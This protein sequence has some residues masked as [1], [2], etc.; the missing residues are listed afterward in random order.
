MAPSCYE[1]IL[2]GFI[3]LL[4][5]LYETSRTFRYYFKFLVYYGI[6]IVNAVLLMPLI[7]LRPGNVKNFLL[8]QGV[9]LQ[10]KKKMRADDC[11]A[12]DWISEV[13]EFLKMLRKFCT[14]KIYIARHSIC[15]RM[16]RNSHSRATDQYYRVCYCA[17]L[18]SRFVFVITILLCISSCK[19]SSCQLDGRRGGRGKS[20]RRPRE[21]IDRYS[22]A[23]WVVMPA[24]FVIVIA[25]VAT[26]WLFVSRVEAE[27]I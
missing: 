22:V 19:F 17:Y 26:A 12:R 9:F 2:V 23:W 16:S 6:V 15:M 7:S 1:V 25:N 10:K 24:V 20:S 4:P 27:K 14:R 18:S 5:F 8:V 11:V 21:F 3:L 13:G